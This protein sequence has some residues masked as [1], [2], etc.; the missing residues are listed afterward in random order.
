MGGWTAGR[1]QT[2]H[3]PGFFVRGGGGSRP[4]GQ[5]TG[6]AHGTNTHAR[7]RARTHTHTYIRMYRQT[8]EADGW[9]YMHMY[10]RQL[11]DNLFKTCI[12][13]YRDNV[14]NRHVRACRGIHARLIILKFPMKMNDLVPSSPTYFIFIGYLKTGGMAGVRAN[15]H[16]AKLDPPLLIHAHSCCIMHE[17][18]TRMYFK[19][20]WA[21]LSY[22]FGPS[23][24]INMGRVGMGRVFCGPSWHVPSWFLGRV[25]RNSIG[26]AFHRYNEIFI[27]EM[28]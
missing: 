18:A 5:N 2:R 14:R 27:L 21:E 24:L 12:I 15:P 11:K 16:E 3:D 13:M 4:D 22:E 1:T 20:I 19:N 26:F 7:A 17:H 25:V 28:R 8:H 9:T 23:C 10:R 6:S